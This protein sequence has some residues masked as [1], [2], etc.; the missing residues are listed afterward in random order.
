MIELN[1]RYSAYLES[2]RPWVQP[3][4]LKQTRPQETQI[5]FHR[6]IISLLKNKAT[7]VLMSYIDSQNILRPCTA[8]QR[9]I[10]T[11]TQDNSQTILSQLGSS[12]H[13][14]I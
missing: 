9:L 2:T 13:E 12:W 6:K 3:L 14:P 10:H 7:Q 11:K 1:L 5:L 4:A 8:Y